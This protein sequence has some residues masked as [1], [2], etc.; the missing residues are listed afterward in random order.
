MVSDP[1]PTPQGTRT[2]LYLALG[3]L[4]AAVAGIGALYG[5]RGSARNGEM[6]Q[7]G[8]CAASATTAAR[9]APL[10]KGEVAALQVQHGPKPAVDV[11]FS[12][13]EGQTLKLSSFR[14]KAVLLNLWATWCAPCKAEMPALDRL[15][16]E[17]GGKDF[18]VVA[19]NIDTQRLE[20]PKA[21]LK[22]AGVNTLAYYS[23]KEAAIF[24][25][26]KR[27][28]KAFGMPTTLLIDANGCELA[29]MAGPADWAGADAKAVIGA[30]LKR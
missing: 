14:G 3:L 20:R 9:M 2:G 25:D 4:L 1:T 6:A 15:Q 13:P 21:F 16:Q 30:M 10:V 23:D 22:D 7:G 24:T 8:A 29:T 17:M 28:G 27:A 18:E 12:S 11:S 19:V 5:I 26:L